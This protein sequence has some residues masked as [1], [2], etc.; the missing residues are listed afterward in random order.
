MELLS[1]LASEMGNVLTTV[2]GAIPFLAAYVGVILLSLLAWRMVKR[3][4]RP[5]HDY[6]SL[7]T[8]TFGDESAVVSNTV[9]SVV[10]IVLI[11]VFW[12]AFTGSKLL[13]GFMHAPGAYVGDGSFTYTLTAPDG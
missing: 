6:G 12:G 2:L 9:A 13:P 8:V 11:F 7:K 4:L 3:V 10:S 5:K 1:K